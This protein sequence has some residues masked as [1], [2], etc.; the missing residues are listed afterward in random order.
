MQ[1]IKDSNAFSFRYCF[2]QTNSVLSTNFVMK[3]V[4]NY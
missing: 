3:K 1:E 4:Q 2:L